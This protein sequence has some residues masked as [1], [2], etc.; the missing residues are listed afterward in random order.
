MADTYHSLYMSKPQKCA[1]SRVNPN[2]NYGLWVIMLCQFRFINY[3][4][5]YHFG[6]GCL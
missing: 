3:N 4:K 1:T 2:V 6:G 5:C